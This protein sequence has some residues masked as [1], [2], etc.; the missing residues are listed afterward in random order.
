MTAASHSLLAADLDQILTRTERLWEPVRNQVLFLTGGTG[1]FGRWLLESFV[2]ANHHFALNAQAIILTRHP[3]AFHAKA[4]HLATD[5]AIRLVAGD[6]RELRAADI[7]SQLGESALPQC[8]LIIHAAAETSQ[9]AARDV[10]LG[11]LDTLVEGTRRVLDFAVQ[12]KA[13]RF[14]C[15]SSGAVYGEQPANL[16]HVT[17]SYSGAPGVTSPLGPYGEGKRVA[18][19][20]CCLYARRHGLNCRIARGFAFVGPFL[21]LEAHFAIGNFIGDALAGNPIRVKGDG[22]PVRSYLYAADLAIWLWTILLHPRAA[23][24]YNVG[25]DAAMSIREVA[26]C[27][28]RHNAS[29][30]PVTVAQRPNPQLAAARYVPDVSRARQELGL[31]VWT[32]LDLAVQKTLTFHRRMKTTS[33]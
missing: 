30:S 12:T 33:L 14:L 16:S 19:L 28:S 8:A 18:E 25:S 4:A 21:P 24:A 32:P 10:P 5:P 7:R 15:I 22:T 9:T 3:A 31:E 26:E 20:L 29:P 23:G 13:E 1:F 11:V 2:A 6:V 27:V 17:E